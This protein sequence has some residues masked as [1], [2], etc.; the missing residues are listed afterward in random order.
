[1]VLNSGAGGSGVLATELGLWLARQGH[2][3][4]FVASSVPFRLGDK[5]CDDVYFHEVAAMPYPLFEGP[6]VTLSEASRLVEVCERFGIDVV[7][8]HYAIPHAAA[9]LL[10]RQMV[11]DVA[12]PAVV[13]TL[14]GTDV[15]L[16]G[17]DPAYL[18]ATQWS[19]ESSDVVTAVSRH[20]ADT[21]VGGL[22]VGRDDIHVV[23]NGVDIERFGPAAA[24]DAV[25]AR[26]AA[27]GEGLVVH[28]SNFRSVKRADDVVRAF[29][30]VRANVPARLV[31]VGDGPE[32][33]R[34]GALARE[35]G[36]GEAV[37]FVGTV[38]RVEALL[39]SADL[40]MLPS[41]Q[42]SFG[43]SALEAMASG[44]P[45][46]AT[47]VGG[48]PEVVEHGVSGFLHELGDVESMA[49]SAKSLLSDPQALAAFGRAARERAATRF[50]E[51]LVFP[52]YVELYEAAVAAASARAAVSRPPSA[53]PR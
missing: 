27:H 46:I 33:P 45:V 53:A 20:L 6:L 8:A 51:G 28:V 24:S 48:L 2:E 41:A 13:T 25:R 42:E 19:I 11:R 17:L 21:T 29:A 52:R 36:V 16:V 38:P 40:F 5:A 37:E 43:L 10:A 4:H 39:A 1:M 50:G 18:R 31:M 44:T 35:L 14:H 15:T 3:V 30:L 34:A 49:A 47:N 7:H 12:P 32:R 26:H 9:A 23:Y 22:G